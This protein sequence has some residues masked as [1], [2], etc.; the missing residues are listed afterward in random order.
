[1][2]DFAVVAIDMTRDSMHSHRALEKRKAVIRRAIPF[3]AWCRTQGLPV[4]FSN[5]LRR[6]TDEWFWSAGWEPHDMVGDPG[7]ETYDPLYEPGDIVVI[8]RRYSSFFDTEL[9]ITLRELKVKS[10]IL[11][12]WSTSVAI[13]TTAIDAWQRCYGVIVPQDL[14]VAHV[15]GGYTVEQQQSWALAYVRTFAI[16]T[17]TTSD[18]IVTTGLLR[19]SEPGKFQGKQD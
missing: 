7:A 10:L 9:D 13:V 18:E 15:W 11:M 3:L 14:T 4:I 16:A 6:P 19:T 5:A 12:G 8:K 2:P 1:M 17:I